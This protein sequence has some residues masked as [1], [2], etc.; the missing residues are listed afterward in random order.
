MLNFRNGR[1][2]PQ[3]SHQWP[4][5]PLEWQVMELV[6]KSGEC[7]VREIARRMPQERAYTTV[8][9]T[10][11]RLFQKRILNRRKVAR[12]F[13]YSARLSRQEVEETFARGLIE[14]MLEIPTTSGAR[15]LIVLSLLERLRG[16]DSEF[17]DAAVT[18]TKAKRN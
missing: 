13:L 5:G 16:Q 14:Q 1:I 9:T 11:C 3:H 7:S 6:W 12:K 8:M 18:M 17:F 4:L 15:Q 2:S 10:L